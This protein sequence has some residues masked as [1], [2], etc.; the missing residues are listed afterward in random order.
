MLWALLGFG[1]LIFRTI[2]W[3]RYHP[4]PSAEEGQAPLLT[5][6]IPAYN[7]GAM[8]KSSI[9]SVRHGPVPERPAGDF[10]VDDGSKDDTWE[11]IRAAAASYP[12]LVTTVRFEKNRENGQP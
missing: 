2:M 11:H 10:A 1:L 9:E 4:F 7:E 6:V 3:L 8:V 5:V 12:G